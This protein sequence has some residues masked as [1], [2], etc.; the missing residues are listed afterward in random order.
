[1]A[2]Q[3]LSISLEENKTCAII[4]VFGKSVSEVKSGSNQFLPGNID[5]GN[6]SRE[7]TGDLPRWKVKYRRG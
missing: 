5:D 4:G 1:M 2:G 3:F 7:K 6:N